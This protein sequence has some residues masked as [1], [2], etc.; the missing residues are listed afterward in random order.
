MLWQLTP[1]EFESS[2]FGAPVARLSIAQEGHGVGAMDA[3]QGAEAWLVSARVAADDQD[4]LADLMSAGF[5]TVETLVTLERGIEGGL[6]MPSGIRL[7]QT[8]D[9]QGCLDIART[10]FRFDRFHTDP[11][12]P[13]VLADRLKE[14]WVA[15]SLDGRADAVVVGE[16]GGRITGFVT[17]MTNGDT[18]IIDLI[19][20]SPDFQGQG[21]G[22]KLVQGALAHYSGQKP[23]MR[24]GTQDGNTQSLALYEGQG[25]KRAHAQVTCHWVDQ[26]RSPS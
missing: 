20:V 5:E 7:V 16:D 18:A 3:L 17:C 8:Q 14:T 21:W 19:A 2:V 23:L 15:N 10:A 12:V 13:D 4:A 6:G 9:R 1:L 11:R 24:V 26:G 25:F 22:K